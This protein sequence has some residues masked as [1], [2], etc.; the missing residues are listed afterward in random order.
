MYY[1]IIGETNGIEIGCSH[2]R[3]NLEEILKVYYFSATKGASQLE[4][5]SMLKS[6]KLT[7]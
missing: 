7:I 5:I 6:S 1:N 2:R 3:H 4:D